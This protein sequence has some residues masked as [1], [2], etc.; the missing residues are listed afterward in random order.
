M[1]NQGKTEAEA[2]TEGAE[3]SREFAGSEDIANARG[4]GIRPD[5]LKAINATD[6]AHR[7]DGK[8]WGVKKPKGR[9]TAK[10]RQFASLVAQG[11][12]PRDAYRKAYNA[13]GSSEAS[14]VVNANRVMKVAKVAGIIESVWEHVE[15]NI[16]DDQVAARRFILDELHGHATNDKNRTGDRLKSL[17]LMGRAIGM[18]TDKTETKVEQIDPDQLKRELDSHLKTF[19]TMQ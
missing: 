9:V 1:E 7:Q 14:V 11:H 12:S 17:E 4:G 5:L 19:K 2:G 6:E 8:P 13:A 18:F 3:N 10:Q 16:I 15:K